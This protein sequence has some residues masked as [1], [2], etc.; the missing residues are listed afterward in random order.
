MVSA[1]PYLP[2]PADLLRMPN[3]CEPASGFFHFSNGIPRDP[4]QKVQPP[5]RSTEYRLSK[6]LTVRRSYTPYP[7]PSSPTVSPFPYSEDPVV[8]RIPGW[9]ALSRI[10]SKTRLRTTR[11]TSQSF[12]GWPRTQLLPDVS[13]S[14]LSLLLILWGPTYD[15]RYSIKFS[16][17]VHNWVS[18]GWC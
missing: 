7:T 2:R 8:F 13:G 3:H 6:C 5:C 18:Q 12:R 11:D 10:T 16:W 14:V 17:N 9:D 4:T 15:T 1:L